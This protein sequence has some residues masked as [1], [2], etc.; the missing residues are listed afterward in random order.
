MKELRAAVAELEKRLSDSV[1][2]EHDLIEVLTR[3]Q[4][5]ELS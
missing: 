4:Q 3:W 1:A 5:R 2:R